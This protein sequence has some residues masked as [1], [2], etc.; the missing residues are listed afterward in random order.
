METSVGNNLFY[1][2]PLPGQVIKEHERLNEVLRQAKQKNSLNNLYDHL[3]EVLDKLVV[4]YPDQALEK[5]EEVSYLIKHKSAVDISQFLKLHDE[6]LACR[7]DDQT[8]A[9]TSDFIKFTRKAFKAETGED[10]EGEESQAAPLGF[11]PDIVSDNKQVFSW[12]G[13]D[14]GEYDCLVLQKSIK[15]L[16]ATVGSSNLRLWGKIFGTEKDFYIVEGT[17]EAPEEEER[18]ENMEPRG[19][20]VNQFAYWVT[21]SPTADWVALP[22]LTAEDILAACSIKVSFTGDLERQIFTNPFYFKTEKYYLRA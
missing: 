16:A 1:L 7:H 10:E 17:A 12:A 9:A 8:A 2:K 19:T 13:I 6:S 18:P 3:T 11:V 14:F 15:K 20:G 4:N 5:L 22:D 21:S